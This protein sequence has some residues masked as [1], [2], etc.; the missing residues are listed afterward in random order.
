[1]PINFDDLNK[2]LRDEVGKVK[3]PDGVNVGHVDEAI[4]GVEM[5]RADI[6]RS[7]IEFIKNINRA[8]MKAKDLEPNT[9]EFNH[10]IEVMQHNI[11]GIIAF[12]GSLI[13]YTSMQ[14]WMKK[15]RETDEK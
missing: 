7:I 11:T 1:M 10:C 13:P 6:K 12:A 4:A 15:M 3:L 14:D 9:D 2:E 8:T 5:I